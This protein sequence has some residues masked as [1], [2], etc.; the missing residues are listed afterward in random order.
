MLVFLSWSGQRSKAAA[1]VLRTWLAEV[2]QVADPWMS[3]DIDKGRRWVEELGEKL[4]R[5]K[6]GILCLTEQSL[7]SQW[8]YFEAGALAKTKD[9]LVCNLLIDLPA[10]RV[11]FPLAQFQ[12]ALT[13]KKDVH[14]LVHSLNRAALR[15]GEA[16][17]KEAVLDRVFEA[18]WPRLEKELRSLEDATYDDERRESEPPPDMFGQLIT[19]VLS[20]AGPN[21]LATEELAPKVISAMSPQNPPPMQP[22]A[23]AL[24]AVEMEN[25]QLPQLLQRGY[26]ERIGARYRLTSVGRERSLEARQRL[27]ELRA[28]LESQF[29]K[30]PPR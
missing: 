19:L 12:H 23:L 5:S 3:T 2:L 6:A 29:G 4:E 30:T 1:E 7:E 9:A 24:L 25:K 22:G 17:L 14:Q 15:S 26:A 11:G 10:D 28:R 20:E 21:G 16:G 13:T 27:S 18:S 8:I